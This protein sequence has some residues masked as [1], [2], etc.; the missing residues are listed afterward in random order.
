MVPLKVAGTTLSSVGPSFQR[1]RYDYTPEIHP[2]RSSDFSA[3]SDKL[4]RPEL[5]LKT[6][7][8]SRNELIKSVDYKGDYRPRLVL[9]RALIL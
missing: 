1:Q 8:F 3:N 2:G 6:S 4:D 9:Q 7:R 5:N